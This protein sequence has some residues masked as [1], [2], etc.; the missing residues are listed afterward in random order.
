[1]NIDI[2]K[3][4]KVWNN[5]EMIIETYTCDKCKKPIQDSQWGI[6]VIS[7]QNVGDNLCNGDNRIIRDIQFCREC[8]SQFIVPIL[9]V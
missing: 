3:Y 1:M 6:Y 2:E 8:F 4:Y 5:N 9:P 7:H